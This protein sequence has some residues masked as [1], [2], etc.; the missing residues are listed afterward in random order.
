[1]LGRGASG[2]WISSPESFDEG[3]TVLRRLAEG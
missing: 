2:A 3:L 1:M